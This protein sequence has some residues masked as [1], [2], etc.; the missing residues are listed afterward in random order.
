MSFDM[1]L[2]RGLDY[3]TGIIYEAVHE[4][5]APPGKTTN[6]PVMA[7]G[8]APAPSP[9]TNAKSSSSKSKKAKAAGN[10][11]DEDEVDESTIG[12]GS[13]AAGGRYDELVG[14]FYESAGGKKGTGR[15]PCVGVSIGVERVFSIMLQKRK[16]AELKEAR[17]KETDVYVVAM[18]GDGLLKERMA[19][20]KQLWEGGIKVGPELVLA[21]TAPMFPAH[22]V[23]LTPGTRPSSC[24]SANQ[25]QTS[26]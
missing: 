21:S 8:V 15:V 23:F 12:V 19:L 14:M 5:S 7:D 1:S 11:G 10:N 9:A 18:G 26:S 6:P 13:I 3:Y 25:S 2:A 4:A 16:D 20:C 22:T 17:G 24:T